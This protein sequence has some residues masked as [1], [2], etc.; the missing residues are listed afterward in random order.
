M[1]NRSWRQGLHQAVEVKENLEVTNP[2]ETLARLSFQRFFR[3]FR[4]LSGMSG[5]AQEAASELWH[6]YKL[7]VVTIPTHRPCVRKTL[8][9]V[10]SPNNESKWD[11]LVH[12]IEKLHETDRPV[13]IGTRSVE[14][15]EKLASMLTSRGLTFNLLNA[16]HHKEEARVF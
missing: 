15:S 6:I 14:A 12:E 8:P 5:T 10:I 16:V 11:A 13:L 3:F 2:S 1:P 9:D 7:P 4:K